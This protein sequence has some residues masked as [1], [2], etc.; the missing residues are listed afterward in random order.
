M[1]EKFRDI[2]F[3]EFKAWHAS[4]AA[5]GDSIALM[6]RVGGSEYEMWVMGKQGV[7]S[8]SWTLKNHHW[9]WP[10]CSWKNK[11]LFWNYKHNDYNLVDES[12]RK[13]KRVKVQTPKH[14]M[15]Y[16]PF[17]YKE[18]LFWIKE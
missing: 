16:A 9:M 14:P 13:V 11:V 18:S 5:Y 12:T 4:L 8:K 7:W 6:R 2:K 10:L 15:K 3:P 17:S 1:T